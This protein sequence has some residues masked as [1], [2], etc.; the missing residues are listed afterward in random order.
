MELELVHSHKQMTLLLL[1]LSLLL[2]LAPITIH[3]YPVMVD[4]DFTELFNR[5]TLGLRDTQDHK[6][7][8]DQHPASKEQECAPLHAT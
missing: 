6:D 1:A 3:T 7:G 5:H 8:H 4:N 2:L